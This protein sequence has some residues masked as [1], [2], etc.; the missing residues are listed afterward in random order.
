VSCRGFFLPVYTR[1]EEE[2]YPTLA[3][4]EFL[5]VCLPCA[6][7]ATNRFKWARRLRYVLSYGLRSWISTV[8]CPYLSAPV[9]PDVR[10]K[11]ACLEPHFFPFTP[12]LALNISFGRLFRPNH[13]W[14]SRISKGN[15]QYNI[16]KYGHFDAEM[17]KWRWLIFTANL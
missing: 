8:E 14:C 1:P 10:Q 11:F 2:V 9:P 6:S 3:E 17:E 16:S 12:W 13:P 4:A 5:K 7:L 15:S